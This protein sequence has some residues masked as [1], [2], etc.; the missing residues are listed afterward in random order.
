MSEAKLAIEYSCGAEIL[1]N[2]Q[3]ID[4]DYFLTSIRFFPPYFD[5]GKIIC[6][7]WNGWFYIPSKSPAATYSLKDFQP[8]VQ[9]DYADG[10]IVTVLPN[11]KRVVKSG[12]LFLFVGSGD[13]PMFFYPRLRRHEDAKAALNLF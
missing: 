8:T 4:D 3:P 9:L 5:D 1:R 12:A 2:G 7:E 10:K 11:E 6:G 13:P